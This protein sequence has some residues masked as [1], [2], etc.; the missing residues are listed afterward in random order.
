MSDS[1]R[2]RRR[3][4]K[5]V[6]KRKNRKY[7]DIQLNIMPFIDVFSVLNTFLL[8]S[9]VFLSIG[10]IKVQIPFFTNSPPPTKPKRSLTVNVDVVLDKVTVQTSY[11]APPV[12]AQNYPFPLTVQ[13]ITD[14]HNKLV[15]IRRSDQETDLVTV[16]SD[17]LVTFEDLSK[18]LDAVKLRR[19]TDPTIENKFTDE[20]DDL[21]EKANNKIFIYPKIV[22][23]SVIL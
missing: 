23:G 20:G 6:A 9:A 8:M 22:M 2:R 17:D 16:F 1:Y 4:K 13:G 14:M 19:P 11:T 18:V 15:E 7:R 12:N 21:I 5:K 10:I 3:H